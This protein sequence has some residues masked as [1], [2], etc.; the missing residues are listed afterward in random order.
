MIKLWFVVEPPSGPGSKNGWKQTQNLQSAGVMVNP[1]KSDFAKADTQY[2]G[3][4]IGIG[5]I[6]PQVN[7]VSAIEACPLPQTREQLRSFL[8]MAGFYQCFIPHFSTRAA[9]LET[10]FQPIV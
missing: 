5:M 10:C 6:K 2:L 7:K 3:Y 4:V 8:S 1:S 9:P